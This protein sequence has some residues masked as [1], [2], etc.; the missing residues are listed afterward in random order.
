MARIIAERR[1][2]DPDSAFPW[3]GLAIEGRIEDDLAAMPALEAGAECL[4]AHP[5]RDTR[6]RSRGRPHP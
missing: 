2:R 1:A 3:S 4:R 6:A 5:S